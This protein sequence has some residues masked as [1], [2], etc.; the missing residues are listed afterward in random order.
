L[1]SGL[2]EVVV[3]CLD[4]V[5]PRPVYFHRL[6]LFSL[7]KAGTACKNKI[8]LGGLRQAQPP[9]PKPNGAESKPGGFD[10]LSH[11]SHPHHSSLS[12]TGVFNSNENCKFAAKH[13][14]FILLTLA[15]DKTN[16]H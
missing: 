14:Q 11:S 8:D 7:L 13:N 3:W 6:S 16:L 12:R 9:Q 4:E 2:D 5:A 15:H 1:G 10:R